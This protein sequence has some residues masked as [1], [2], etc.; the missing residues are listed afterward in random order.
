MVT[1]LVVAGLVSFLVINLLLNPA[2]I[3]KDYR[4]GRKDHAAIAA[5][6]LVVFAAVMVSAIV[7]LGGNLWFW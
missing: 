4:E 6:E 7:L 3:M 5:L 1:V 2:Q